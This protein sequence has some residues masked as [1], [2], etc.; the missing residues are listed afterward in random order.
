MISFDTFKNEFMS[1][2]ADMIRDHGD[3]DGHVPA[4]CKIMHRELGLT[5]TPSQEAIDYYERLT[6]GKDAP[7]GELYLTEEHVQ[8]HT[9]L[10]QATIEGAMAGITSDGLLAS[11]FL[12]GRRMG[13]R[14]AAQAFGSLDAVDA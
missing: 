3:E 8:L 14:E 10:E 11:F 7:E 2:Q 13:M 1:V 5:E 4:P 6:G 9:M 12:I